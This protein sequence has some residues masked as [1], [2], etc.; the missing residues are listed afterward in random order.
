[1]KL[2]E[3]RRGSIGIVVDSKSLFEKP[4]ENFTGEAHHTF[5]YHGN[6]QITEAHIGK[7][8]ELLPIDN[9]FDD[10]KYLVL[11]LEPKM[12][13]F[14]DKHIQHVID[15][16]MMDIGKKYEMSNILAKV[17]P[18]FRHLVSDKRR[19][20]SEHT[21]YG[22]SDYHKFCGKKYTY[23]SP[24]DILRDQWLFN[25]DKFKPIRLVDIQI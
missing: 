15:L 6:G 19:V 11:V 3:L 18:A 22:Y 7:C 9:Y 10:D 23:V 17:F 24:N 16:W 13:V 4:I 20:C 5:C 14:S 25:Y 2:S 1:M 12:K 8:I 21:A